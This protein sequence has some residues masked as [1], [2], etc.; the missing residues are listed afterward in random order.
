MTLETTESTRAQAELTQQNWLA[1]G[2]GHCPGCGWQS[3]TRTARDSNEQQAK[4]NL[5]TSLQLVH[6]LIKRKACPNGKLMF[7]ISTRK[8]K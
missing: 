4:I 6:N 1:E 2:S 8:V 7:S 5:Q 3:P